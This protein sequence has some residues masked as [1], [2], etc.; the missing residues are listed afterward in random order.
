MRTGDVV[1]LANERRLSAVLDFAPDSAELLVLNGG[2]RAEELTIST[3]VS[4]PVRRERR[5]VYCVDAGTSMQLLFPLLVD[6]NPADVTVRIS[7]SFDDIVLCPPPRRSVV[8]LPALRG[9]LAATAAAVLLFVAGGRLDPSSVIAIADP[10]PAASAPTLVTPQHAGLRVQQLPSVIA[11]ASIV[12]TPAFT[13]ARTTVA[14]ARVPSVSARQA[15]PARR[16]PLK[17]KVF[18][19]PIVASTRSDRRSVAEPKMSNL[20]VPTTARNGDLVRVAY[21]A[22]AD[23]VRIVASIGPTVV[24]KKT[25][26]SKTGVVAFRPPASNR[27]GRVMTIRAYAMN[28]NR[29]SSLQAMVVLVG[30]G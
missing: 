13:S 22:I 11:R 14:F 9:G 24:A 16:I 25:V 30:P 7:G 12:H 23:R 29:T 20:A 4:A 8:R 2:S 18:V 6:E 26:S 3:V 27:D 21:R 17:R 5:A 10:E 15:V 19:Q 28:G 1:D